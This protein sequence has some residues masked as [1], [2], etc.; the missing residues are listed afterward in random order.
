MS[1]ALERH[2]T[3][4]IRHAALA[5]RKYYVLLLPVPR[6]SSGIPELFRQIDTSPSGR[7]RRARRGALAGY[8]TGTRKHECRRGGKP[9]A[10]F[11][12]REPPAREI[13]AHLNLA[14]KA[15]ISQ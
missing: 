15:G 3:A 10:R 11:P 12:L 9:A 8:L 1:T 5:R 7:Q 2:R 4:S 6:H 13:P 14:Q